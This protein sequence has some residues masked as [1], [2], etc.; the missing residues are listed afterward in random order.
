LLA[1]S[2]SVGVLVL[3][4]DRPRMLK[5]AERRTA[6]HF[7]DAA[8]LLLLNLVTFDAQG[9][10]LPVRTLALGPE[11]HQA[12]GAVAV[13]A[14]CTVEEALIRL[15]AHALA[16]DEPLTQV[17]RQVLAHTLRFSKQVS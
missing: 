5:E 2:A 15:R 8:L 16:A 14:D 3:C 4:Q 11:I 6:G 9:E 13:Q 12:S 10:V 1:G 17:A 7:A